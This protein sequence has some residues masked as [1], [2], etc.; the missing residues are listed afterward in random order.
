MKAKELG[1]CRNKETMEEIK[2]SEIDPIVN[3]V[4]MCDRD[5]F[6][7]LWGKVKSLSKFSGKIDY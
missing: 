4:L 1:Q 6:P 3:E 5:D 2:E 7:N